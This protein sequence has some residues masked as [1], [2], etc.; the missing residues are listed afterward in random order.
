MAM[1]EVTAAE[2]LIL[3]LLRVFHSLSGKERLLE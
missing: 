1:L 3:W 2:T